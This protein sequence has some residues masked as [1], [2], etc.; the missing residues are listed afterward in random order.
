MPKT[1][2]KAAKSKAKAKAKRSQARLDDQPGV[3][4]GSF[5]PVHPEIEP[6]AIDYREKRDIRQAA[7][8]PEREARAKLHQA[9]IKLDVMLYPV[10]EDE[11]ARRK[12]GEETV[13]VNKT[14]EGKARALK[15][16]RDAKRAA[17]GALEVID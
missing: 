16:K 10:G 14:K 1:P 7:E 3:D 12:P 15:A 13:T 17:Q 4:A 11:E 2:K 9:M 6:L 8:T 5:I